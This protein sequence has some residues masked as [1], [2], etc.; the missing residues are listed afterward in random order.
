MEH[1][2]AF[3][4]DSIQI[5]RVYRN[6]I[7]PFNGNFHKQF[8]NGVHIHTF[9]RLHAILPELVV[10]L[11]SI[12]S[13]RFHHVDVIMSPSSSELLPIHIFLMPNVGLMWTMFTRNCDI[14]RDAQSGGRVYVFVSMEIGRVSRRITGIFGCSVIHHGF[15]NSC[16][17]Q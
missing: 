7:K 15:S 2:G 11:F 4:R 10:N 9:F 6:E 14:G 3:W 8:E 1:R 17:A 5:H 13:E 12:R 16:I